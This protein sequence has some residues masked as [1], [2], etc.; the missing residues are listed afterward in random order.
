MDRL[1]LY[2]HWPFCQSKCPYCDFNSHVSAQIDET[3]WKHA[4]TRELERYAADTQ[5]QILSTI[6]FGGGTPSLM[7]AEL[8]A[9]VIEEARRLWPMV[10]DPEITLEANPGSVEHH[11]FQRFAEVGVNRVS[12]G[13]QALN[14]TDLRKLGRIHSAL[15]GREAIETAKAVFDRVSFDLIYARQDQSLAAWEDELTEALGFGTDH[16]SLYQLTVEP[17][18]VFGARA[19]RGLLHGLP[20]EDLAADMYDLTQEI[21]SNAGLP[22]YETSN[23]A[24]AGNESR[25]NL[26]YWTGGSYLG[27]GPGAHG[28]LEKNAER[29]ATETALQPEAW[30]EGVEAR[31]SGET[32]RTALS[33]EDQ[34]VEY[35]M[36]GLR[37][38]EG[39]SLAELSA[40][41]YALPVSKIDQLVADCFVT[42]SDNRLRLTQK[43]RPLLNAVLRELLV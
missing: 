21:T 3:R 7:S 24:K 39:V 18:T 32:E 8:V 14:D 13:I 23:H 35:L 27:V 17:G 28:R 1:G 15:E 12:I 41:S 26:I 5:G 16:V 11:K 10:N 34:A 38:T 29:Y 9:H 22:A 36:M 30:L 31:G 19:A 2:I 37:L 4:Y 43:G 25:H 40:F 6:F 33:Q 42:V 20:G